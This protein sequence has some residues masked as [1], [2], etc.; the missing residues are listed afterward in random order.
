MKICIIF[1]SMTKIPPFSLSESSHDTQGRRSTNKIQRKVATESKHRILRIKEE[2]IKEKTPS[3]KHLAF[4]E[5][6]SSMI[7][8]RLKDQL[9]RIPWSNYPALASY[10]NGVGG[11]SQQRLQAIMNQLTSDIRVNG[12]R[13]TPLQA[14]I[15]QQSSNGDINPAT[16]SLNDMQ[17]DIV[18]NL[19]NSMQP[20]MQENMQDD[21]YGQHNMPN[22]MQDDTGESEPKPIQ[23]PINTRGNNDQLMHPSTFERLMFGSLSQIV[24][25]RKGEN[26]GYSDFGGGMSNVPGLSFGGRHSSGVINL[27]ESGNGL[28]P[29]T[30]MN[31]MR[32]MN[33]LYTGMMGTMTGMERTRG[34]LMGDGSF[35]R[36]GET[37]SQNNNER[38][39]Q[40]TD[41][42]ASE[43]VSPEIK[44]YTVSRAEKTNIIQET[45][46]DIIRL[47]PSDAL[48][49]VQKNSKL[50]THKKLKKRIQHI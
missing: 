24:G 10:A 16:S 49:P 17:S 42:T 4:Q 35:T 11:L 19:H 33:G 47:I 18:N 39:S 48:S 43:S 23:L 31:G 38:S 15:V 40:K 41:K 50:K 5:E 29:M 27:M 9:G 21:A 26:K 25:D 34:R 14:Q 30:G 2:P 46:P 20:N 13:V 6:S 1:F 36:R 32:S 28:K 22:G 7:K 8:T 45:K 3:R 44:G 12:R 37:T